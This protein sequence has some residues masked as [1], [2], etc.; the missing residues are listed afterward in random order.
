MEKI[1]AKT[2]TWAFS[3]EKRQDAARNF[4]YCLA[5]QVL[6]RGPDNANFRWEDHSK[7]KYVVCNRVK[8]EVGSR[9]EKTKGAKKAEKIESPW[10]GKRQVLYRH[11]LGNPTTINQGIDAMRKWADKVSRDLD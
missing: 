4:L 8:F 9:F 7:I 11:V 2:Y 5:R 3:S 6:E 10:D 1:C